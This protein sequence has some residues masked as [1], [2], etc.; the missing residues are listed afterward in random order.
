MSA[1]FMLIYLA[2]PTSSLTTSAEP[3]RARTHRSVRNIGMFSGWHSQNASPASLTPPTQPIE[4]KRRHQRS[5]LAN[6]AVPSAFRKPA[7]PNP[8]GLAPRRPIIPAPRHCA[9]SPRLEALKEVEE[10]VV[11]EEDEEPDFVPRSFRSRRRSSVSSATSS[12]AS[13]PEKDEEVA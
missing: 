11:E 5:Y 1:A 3:E 2:S 8:F 9:V 12:L 10:E 7:D 6:G 13:I 4:R